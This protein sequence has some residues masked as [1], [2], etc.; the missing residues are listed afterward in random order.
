MGPPTGM[1]TQER[2]LLC[3]PK[4]MIK[5]AGAAPSLTLKAQQLQNKSGGA[6]LH[7]F[8]GKINGKAGRLASSLC[9]DMLEMEPTHEGEAKPVLASFPCFTHQHSLEAQRGCKILLVLITN[10]QN[11]GWRK[12]G[13]GNRELHIAPSSKAKPQ[14]RS[15]LAFATETVHLISQMTTSMVKGICRYR[16]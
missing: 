9:G 2:H 15:L 12:K 5:E 14:A 11:P 13:S 4:Q 6:F 16:S 3:G 1:Q 10:R 8:M 7:L